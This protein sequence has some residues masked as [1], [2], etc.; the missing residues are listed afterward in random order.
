MAPCD[1]E[2]FSAQLTPKCIVKNYLYADV[3]QIIAPGGTG[4]T[5]LLLYEAA[6]IALGREIWGLRVECPGWTL[7]V[8]KEDQRE[9]LIAR[10]RAICE[11]LDLSRE[12]TI[13]VRNSVIIRDVTGNALKLLFLSEGNIQRTVF[14]QRLVDAHRGDPPVQVI[15]D[16]TISFGASE[17]MVNDN[18]DALVQVARYLVGELDCCVRYVHHTG[19]ANARAVNVDQYSGR[20][21]TAMPDGSRMTSTLMPAADN[22]VLPQGCGRGEGVSVLKLD[23]H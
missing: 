15:F 16:P 9:R 4:K 2:W 7:I 6:C 11:S 21:G 22:D 13:I 1:E 10:L 5:T 12:E 3:G 17:S 23:R 14:A 8:S 18:E 19:K 20:G